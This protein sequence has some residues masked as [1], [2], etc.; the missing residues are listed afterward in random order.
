M[1]KIGY[2][3]IF[4]GGFA[5]HAAITFLWAMVVGIVTMI[6]GSIDLELIVVSFFLELFITA[7]ICGLL[8]MLVL[9]IFGKKEEEYVVLSR[10]EEC[11]KGSGEGWHFVEEEEGGDEEEGGEEEEDDGD[12]ED[13]EEDEG[14][15][16]W[17]DFFKS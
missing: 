15:D 9:R 12:E 5:V 14:D 4:L 1:K 13:E 2:G 6:S 3:R 17:A 11:E 8:C 16:A 10:E 7:P